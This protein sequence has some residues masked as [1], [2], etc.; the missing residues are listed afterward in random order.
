MAR[1]PAL[2]MAL[3]LVTATCSADPATFYNP[4]NGAIT[5]CVSSDLDPFL[6]R[7]IMTYQRAGWVR[8]TG[9]IIARER[10]PTVTPP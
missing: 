7:C 3:A 6:D 5:E 8:M 9:P 10:P 4:T 2:G 1:T